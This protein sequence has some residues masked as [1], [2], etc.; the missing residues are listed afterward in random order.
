M[1]VALLILPI[2]ML[3]SSWLNL[4]PLSIYGWTTTATIF[5]SFSVSLAIGGLIA[6]VA[7]RKLKWNDFHIL[8]LY[9]ILTIGIWQSAEINA[10]AKAEYEGNTKSSNLPF[11]SLVVPV[12][13]KEWRLVANK[14][15][16]YFVY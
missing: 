2:N 3:P 1:G 5:I 10:K 7:A 14:V 11:V 15:I 8:L 9:I 6:S 12:P 16:E 4:S 13:G